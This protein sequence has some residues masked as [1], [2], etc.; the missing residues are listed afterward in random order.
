MSDRPSTWPARS[1]TCASPASWRWVRCCCPAAARRRPRPPPPYPRRHVRR[2]PDR[3]PRRAPASATA[4]GP[5]ARS[6]LPER[7]RPA[8]RWLRSPQRG[9]LIAGRRPGQVPRRLPRPADRAS[10]WAPTSTSSIRSRGRSSATPTRSS[11]SCSTS[12]TGPTRCSAARSTSSSTPSPSPAPDSAPSSSP[13]P[14]CPLRSACSYRSARRAGRPGRTAGVHLAGLD[15]QDSLRALPV[16]WTWCRCA[17]SRTAWSRCSGA[18]WRPCP[19]TTSSSPGWP[20]QNPQTEI[21]GRP[22]AHSSYAVGMR[23]DQPDLVR[24]VNALLERSRD[25]GSLAASNQR[26]FGGALD[27]VPQPPP[28]RYRD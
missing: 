12:P 17:A 19:A 21:V 9:R 8:R 22:L 5:T 7:C 28:A 23:P 27:P 25:D 20:S 15:D 11:S 6:R 24:F 18:R 16:D 3:R 2:R 4:C 10:S 14:T 26:W 13:A 1:A